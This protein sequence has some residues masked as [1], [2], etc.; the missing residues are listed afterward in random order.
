MDYIKL[1]NASTDS[2]EDPE[3][4]DSFAEVVK[5]GMVTCIV[6]FVLIVVF[7]NKDMWWPPLYEATCGSM[8]CCNPRN[9]YCIGWSTSTF[10]PCWFQKFHE[11]IRLRMAI[12]EGW[13]LRRVDPLST[14]QVFVLILCGNNPA[15]TTAV[16]TVPT[17]NDTRPVEWSDAVDLEVAIA[18]EFIT[19]QVIDVDRSEEPEVVGSTTIR[20]SEML[21]MMADPENGQV[22]GSLD[23]GGLALER[24]TK[25]LMF[26]GD[27]AGEL[28]LSLYATRKGTPLPPMLPG[29]AAHTE[30][31]QKE[32]LT[33]TLRSM[34][35]F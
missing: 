7:A 25:T 31:R 20:V 6:I 33:S 12:H 3:Q 29:M 34:L 21:E 23:G 5:N 15:K 32:S 35:L 17:H 27:D 22:G 14:M 2:L 13:Y 4:Y 9:C 11:P 30:R 8:K 1:Y 16:R 19:L 10:C 24:V 28:L 18:D 26:E